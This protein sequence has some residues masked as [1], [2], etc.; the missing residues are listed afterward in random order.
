MAHSLH[1]PQ[2]QVRVVLIPQKIMFRVESVCCKTSLYTIYATD[3]HLHKGR[4][5]SLLNTT[6]HI[7]GDLHNG[8]GDAIQIDTAALTNALILASVYITQ[9]T[10]NL[11]I[12]VG[13]FISPLLPKLSFN[14]TNT[15]NPDSLRQ[16]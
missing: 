11:S 9:A 3:H 6:H 12:N 8:V 1:K 7:S 2:R 10:R 15:Y 14:L 4:T 5:Y 13:M 16:L